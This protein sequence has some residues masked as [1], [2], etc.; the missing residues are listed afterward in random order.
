MASFAYAAIN[1]Q[2]LE[3]EGVVNAP[4][5]PAAREQLRVKGLLAQSIK[6]QDTGANI[7][8]KNISLGA[9][10][11]KS[12]SLQIFSRQ[13]A[14]MIEAGL[15]VVGALVILEEQTDDQ[16]LA[17]VVHEL[18][19]DVE[20][21]LLLSEAMARHPKI[22]TRLYISMV[23]AG[24]AA[25][26]LDIVLDRVAF[27]IEKQEAIRRRIKG[28]MIYP[29]M[30]LC[31]A[32][33]V[34][35]GMLMFLVPVFVKIFSQLGGQLPT[36]TQYVVTA[37]D[38]LKN[39]PYV[40]LII[41]AAL[42]SFF[43]WKK[44][45]NGRQNWDK[46]KL[47]LPMKIGDVVLKV[48]MAR[49]SRTLSTLVAAGVD[50][51]KALKI[52]GQTSGNWVVEDALATVR[53]KVHEGVPIAQPLLDNPVFPPMVA[54]MVKIGEET[55]ELEKM[56]AKIADFYEDEVDASVG[57]LTSIV[58][59]IMMLGVGIMVGIVIISMYLPMFKMLTLVK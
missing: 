49:F 48:S 21:G 42:W 26:I 16:A 8:S 29:T 9:K 13:F 19:K 53:Q 57:A 15:N 3:T 58:E 56:L 32:T 22:F 33:L 14:T 24:E 18:R 52:T 23:E 54:Q 25:G 12:K 45:E 17:G 38:L 10:K 28:A 34:L 1:A 55:G 35:V 47:K 5:L 36:L 11:V 41:P 31:F 2:G 51:I 44:T 50:I 40:L 7:G 30:V 59:P 6:E 43:R 27:Q 39:K 4:D 20:G 37:S 46:F